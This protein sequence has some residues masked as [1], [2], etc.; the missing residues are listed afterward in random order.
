MDQ[1][2]HK[3]ISA[4]FLIS[5]TTLSLGA[6]EYILSGYLK[7]SSNGETLIGATA[8]VTETGQ[9]VSSNEYGFYSISLEKGSYTLVYDYLGFETQ[10]VTIELNQN[11]RKDIEMQIQSALLSEVVVVGEAEDRNVTEV[12]MSTN[13]LDIATIKSM[14][15]LLGE[16]EIIR[17]IQLLPGVTSVGVFCV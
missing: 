11:T 3:I 5:C 16:I 9:G 1:M 2:I 12:E 10:V 8:F 14:P 13:K 6:Q 17:S 4:I 7:D 15:S